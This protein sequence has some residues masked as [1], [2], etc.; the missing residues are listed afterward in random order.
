MK[1]AEGV[2]ARDEENRLGI[3]SLRKEKDEVGFY[4]MRIRPAQ[5]KA[6]QGRP[7]N[8]KGDGEKM[9]FCFVKKYLV[10]R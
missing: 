4:G 7:D 10:L 3:S 8:G 9:L 6:V 1:V 5:A 2:E